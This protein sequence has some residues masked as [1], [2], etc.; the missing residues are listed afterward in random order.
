[1]LDLKACLFY[2]MQFYNKLIELLITYEVEYDNPNPNFKNFVLKLGHRGISQGR[3]GSCHMHQQCH[4]ATQA[5]SKSLKSGRRHYS[6]ETWAQPERPG[7]VPTYQL[8]TI[9]RQTRLQD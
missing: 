8:T 9:P 5:L 6:A 2:S 1:M 4:T 3:S 7:V